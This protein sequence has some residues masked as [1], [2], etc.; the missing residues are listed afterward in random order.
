MGPQRETTPIQNTKAEQSAP[1]EV[2]TTPKARS[3]MSSLR[4]SWQII[5][6]RR[7]FVLATGITVLA[8]ILSCIL[9]VRPV[10]NSVGLDQSSYQPTLE[11][12][13]RRCAS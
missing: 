3:V 13:S 9:G 1:P 6:Y 12:I 5:R 10:A 7:S 2:A 4:Q 11:M 8:I